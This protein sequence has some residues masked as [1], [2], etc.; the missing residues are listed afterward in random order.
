MAPAQL[1]V[2][3]DEDTGD[4]LYELLLDGERVPEF[5]ELTS[6]DCGARRARCNPGPV[7][8]WPPDPRIAARPLRAAARQR[9][10]LLR[11]DDGRLRG[12]GAC[13]G[14][15]AAGGEGSWHG[16]DQPHGQ[17]YRVESCRGDEEPAVAEHRFSEF[18][19]LDALIRSTFYSNHLLNSVPA[20][21]PKG[22]KL[23]ADQLSPQF[24]EQRCGAAR[25]QS[26]ARHAASLPSP[27]FL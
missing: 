12:G 27:P 18:A 20:L 7:L 6:L 15:V 11:Q 5:N 14:A 16:P 2:L 21:P 1:A 24:L 13:A 10:I 26:L 22:S 8:P 19:D 4:W 23:L 17:M 25:S 3:Y 9:R